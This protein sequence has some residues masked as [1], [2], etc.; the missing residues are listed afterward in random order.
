[1]HE[2]KSGGKTEKVKKVGVNRYFEQSQ[3]YVSIR[4]T[5]PHNVHK[6]NKSNVDGSVAVVREEVRVRDF[7][8]ALAF[9]VPLFDV[10]TQIHEIALQPK[11]GLWEAILEN[12]EGV[13]ILVR[14]GGQK[15]SGQDPFHHGKRVGKRGVDL[16]HRQ[17]GI[18]DR[19]VFERQGFAGDESEVVKLGVVLNGVESRR[20]EDDGSQDFR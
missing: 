19:V 2:I 18:I 16:L 11:V 13:E 5:I 6:T 12:V 4:S 20:V 7:L 14:V 15:V 8:V 1:M 10:V 9:Q 17:F 3:Q